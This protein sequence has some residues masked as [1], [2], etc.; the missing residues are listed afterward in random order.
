MQAPA[1]QLDHL[2]ERYEAITSSVEMN[3]QFAAQAQVIQ[4]Q[5]VQQTFR[6]Q[7]AALQRGLQMGRMYSQ[8][9]DPLWNQYQQRSQAQDEIWNGYRQR[10]AMWDHVQDQ[11]VHTIRNTEEYYD[12]NK[13]RNEELA[14]ATASLVEPERRLYPDRR[15]E[16]RPANHF[17]KNVTE[18]Q[19]PWPAAV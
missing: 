17:I 1:G 18:I 9:N 5:L 8:M 14:T 15:R 13:G 19:S 11:W 16:F 3:P 6:M 2:Q 4:Q 12:P 10:D 7:S